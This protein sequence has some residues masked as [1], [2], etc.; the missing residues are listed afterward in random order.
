MVQPRLIHPIKVTFQII[1]HDDSVFDPYAREPVGQVV[2]EGESPGTGTEYTF[3]AQVSFY[4]AGARKDYVYHDR[5]GVE[6]ET[7]M[8]IATTYKELVKVGLLTLDS[9]GNFDTML[10][11]R[12]DRM[13]RWGR[14]ACNYYVAGFKPFGHYPKQRQTLIQINLEDRHPGY[15]QGDL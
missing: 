4:Y 6:E 11:K 3:K 9:N 2:R 10:L 12:G 15:Q 8:Y 14:E 5:P 1:D 7:N 13:V